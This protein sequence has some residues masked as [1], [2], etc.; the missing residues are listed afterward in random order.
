MNLW[1]QILVIFCLSSVLVLC[2]FPISGPCPQ[3]TSVTNVTAESVIFDILL[4]SFNDKYVASS[5]VDRGLVHHCN[6]SIFLS[7]Q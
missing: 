4:K 6:N 5:V 7:N 1:L 3:V 2:Q